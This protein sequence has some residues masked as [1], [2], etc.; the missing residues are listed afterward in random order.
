MKWEQTWGRECELEN[1]CGVVGLGKGGEESGVTWESGVLAKGSSVK[2]FLCTNPKEGLI[3]K[4][5]IQC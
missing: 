4:V 2:L 5:N 3:L 1:T